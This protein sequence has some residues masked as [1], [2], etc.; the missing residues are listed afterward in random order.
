[1]QPCIA[2][3]LPAQVAGDKAAGNFDVRLRGRQSVVLLHSHSLFA[4]H[5]L[6]QAGLVPCAAAAVLLKRLRRCRRVLL[7]CQAPLLEATAAPRPPLPEEPSK[8]RNRLQSPLPEYLT[9]EAASAYLR[10]GRST[11]PPRWNLQNFLNN[12]RDEVFRE[13]LQALTKWEKKRH[14]MSLA[15]SLARSSIERRDRKIENEERKEELISN[16]WN[17]LFS[18]LEAFLKQEDPWQG[19]FGPERPFI[20]AFPGANSQE[21]GC[22]RCCLDG[23]LTQFG[24]DG[25][26]QLLLLKY[27]C[28]LPSELSTQEQEWEELAMGASILRLEGKIRSSRLRGRIIYLGEDPVIEK[29][30]DF[31]EEDLEKALASM[32]TIR[33]ELLASTGSPVRSQAA[34]PP[35]LTVPRSGPGVP[36]Q[37]SRSKVASKAS[38]TPK[39]TLKAATKIVVAGQMSAK[40][41]PVE[42]AEPVQHAEPVEDA[43]PAEGTSSMG[44]ITVVQDLKAAEKVVEI[45]RS[46]GPSRMHAVDTE[47]DGWAPGNSPYNSGR[48]IC[49]SVYCGEDVD[50]GTGPGLWVDLLHPDGEEFPELLECFRDYLEDPNL[51]KVFHNYSFDRAMFLNMGIR[52]AGFAADTMQM[53]FLWSSG[54]QSE[55]KGYSLKE[56]ST[57]LLGP[58]FQKR[59][60]YAEVSGKLGLGKEA[61]LRVDTRELWISYS[62]LD[63]VATWHLQKELRRRLSGLEWVDSLRDDPCGER[64]TMA[65]YYDTVWRSFGEVLVDMEERG[66][67]LDLAK[68]NASAEKAN[69][70]RLAIQ[71]E[72]RNWLKE[73]WAEDDFAEASAANFNM[74]STKQL[75]TLL[76]GDPEMPDVVNSTVI[77]GLGLPMNLASDMTPKG[78]V[79]MAGDFVAKLSGDPVDGSFGTAYQ[80]I[81][82]AGCRALAGLTEYKLILKASSSFLGPLPLHADSNGRVHSSFQPN[83]STGRLTSVQPNLQQIPKHDTDVYEVRSAFAAPPGCRLIVADYGQLELRV[84]A[85]LTGCS[86]LLEALSTDCDLHSRTACKLFPNVQAALDKGTVTLEHTEDGKPTV[87]ELFSGERKKAKNVTFGIIYGQTKYG[88]SSKQKIEMKEAQVLIDKW[89]E[90]HPEVEVWKKKNWKKALLEGEVKTLRGRRRIVTSSTEGVPAWKARGVSAERERQASNAPV[91]GSAVDIVVEAMIKVNSSARLRE[92][93]YRLVLQVHDELVLEGPEENAEEAL[94]L[95]REAMEHPF[96]DDKE[97]LVPLTVDACIVKRWG[98][99]GG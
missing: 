90:A 29:E 30:H 7:R 36:A 53:A 6:I 60:G 46:L 13:V 55:Q 32:M 11:A 51:P 4:K 26:P 45:L 10:S 65:D 95:L 43:K 67:Y 89:F 27:K 44:R 16:C 76:F 71:V 50:F 9:P 64:R 74:G 72:F 23:M 88:L 22:L 99:A 12:L 19:Y 14:S 58:E 70:R 84:L 86:S 17:E 77:R 92:L 21:L 39:R 48:V 35:P 61:Q 37:V 20:A 56:L 59:A 97:L 75:G 91:Q 79:S 1:M 54:R 82:E 81:G 85:H 5:S 52:V 78:A 69:A 38:K 41:K 3:S 28:R 94:E 18:M 31:L 25:E 68:L 83:T 87:K 34:T 57:E 24:E 40:A 80:Y 63:S 33:E 15:W 73:I 47:T 2:R 62:V 66:M 96:L 8:P 93:G 98:E 49:F 42:P